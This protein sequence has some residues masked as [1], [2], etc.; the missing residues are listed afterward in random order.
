MM[1][2][3]APEESALRYFY[4]P[5]LLGAPREFAL[6]AAGIRWS[7]G[8]HSGQVPYTA[9][10]RVRLSYRP[11]NLQ[12]Y[13]FVT[14][15]W[16]Q[17]APNLTII[18]T[19][20]KSMAVQERLDTSYA[21]FVVALHDRIMGA[22]A[23]VRW[24]KGTA[25]LTYWPGLVVFAIVALAMAAL[26]VRALQVHSLTAAIFVAAFLAVFLW[27]GGNFFRRNRP[28]FYRPDA[29]PPYLIPKT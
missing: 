11:A 23:A 10:R 24:E 21:A 28:G 22:G 2:T 8:R 26:I 15:V 4:R 6:S 16:A 1:D 19:S 27:Q 9:V 12:T 13:R 14:E 3:G 18:S 7:V 29:L 17:G 5:S 25:L 20:W